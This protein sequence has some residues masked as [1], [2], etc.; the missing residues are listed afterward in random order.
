LFCLTQTTVLLA[1]PIQNLLGSGGS[2]DSGQESLSDSKRLVKNLQD[3]SD[4]VGGAA[5]VRHDTA[6]LGGCIRVRVHTVDESR[7]IRARGGDEDTLCLAIVDVVHGKVS[8]CE[9]ASTFED[10]VD[11]Q[12]SPVELLQ[13]T[14]GGK[15]DSLAVNGDEVIRVS[16]DIGTLIQITH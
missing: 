8:L 16:L 6:V 13:V 14:F 5:G 4:T 11:A 3:G 2:V 1:V 7:R 15:G 12:C 10:I 9:F